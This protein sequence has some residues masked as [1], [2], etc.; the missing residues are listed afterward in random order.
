M[1]KKKS[2][3]PGGV[4][5]TDVTIVNPVE[6]QL[7]DSILEEIDAVVTEKGKESRQLLIEAY[8]LVGKLLRESEK[9]FRIS[10]TDLVKQLAADDRM[11]QL[12]M[13]TSNLW[14]SMTVYE[15]YG[16][17]IEKG[18]FEKLPEGENCSISKLKKLLTTPKPAKIPT[19][20]EVAESIFNKYK[21]SDV[22]IIVKELQKLIKAAK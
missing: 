21:L 19:L 2:L 13:G 22:K 7:V 20:D 14:F 1:A 15:E 3:H 10:I 17:V 6:R 12:R 9:K 11:K 5:T 4:E 16:K 18:E 8:Y